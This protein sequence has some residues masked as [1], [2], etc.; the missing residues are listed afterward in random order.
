MAPILEKRDHEA[1]V[2]RRVLRQ[3]N[4]KPT[5]RCG[6]GLGRGRFGPRGGRDADDLEHR[7]KQLRCLDRLAE[8][9]RDSECRAA[10]G[11]ASEVGGRKQHDGRAGELAI[12]LNPFGHLE[13]VHAGHEDVEQTPGRT[14][15]RRRGLVSS[16]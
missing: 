13:A 8:K 12:A 11:I 4:L 10:L 1:L 7:V 5:C 9:N 2:D 6:Q 15:R 3:K 14:A 16:P